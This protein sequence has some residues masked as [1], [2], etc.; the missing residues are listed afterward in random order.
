MPAQYGWLVPD[1]VV[2]GRVTDPMTAEHLEEMTR[3]ATGYL[4]AGA[5]NGVHFLVDLQFR[6][7]LVTLANVRDIVYPVLSHPNLG[8]VVLYGMESDFIRVLIDTLLRALRKSFRFM[9]TREDAIAF[10]Q[11]VDPTLPDLSGMP[12]ALANNGA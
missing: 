1:R 8:W 12:S 2:C 9:A 6:R 7:R 10:L 3:T 5:A 4:D 11:T